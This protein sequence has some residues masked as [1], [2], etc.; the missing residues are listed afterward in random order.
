MKQKQI[1]RI[2]LKREET[3]LEQNTF[4]NFSSLREEMIITYV[5][6]M[7]EDKKND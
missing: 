3:F 2:N 4:I 5:L 6:R 1:L 7:A